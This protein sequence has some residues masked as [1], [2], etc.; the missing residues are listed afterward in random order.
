[1]NRP[2]RFGEALDQYEKS[3]AKRDYEGACDHLIAAIECN[4]YPGLY[5]YLAQS[6]AKARHLYG[7][8]VEATK[9]KTFFTKM[10]TALY[11]PLFK[12]EPNLEDSG[13]MA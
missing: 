4:P 1:M 11:S 13:Y 6:L 12:K 7:V 10:Q 3:M 8:E 9:P 2:D 5:E